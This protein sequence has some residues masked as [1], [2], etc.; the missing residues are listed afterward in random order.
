MRHASIAAELFVENRERLKQ[1]LL[2]NSLAVVNARFAKPL[3]EELLLRYA[4]PGRAII[5]AEEGILAG[6]L[7]S[8]VREF[9]DGRHKFDVRFKAIGLPLEI[10]PLGKSEEIRRAQGLDAAGLAGQIKALYASRP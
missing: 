6:G 9:L 2:P 7:G 8:A 3:D 1:R 5:T 4:L 10:Y